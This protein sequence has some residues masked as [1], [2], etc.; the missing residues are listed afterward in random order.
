MG[1]LLGLGQASFAVPG[2]QM[3]EHALCIN[4][5]PLNKYPLHLCQ[6]IFFILHYCCC[7]VTKSCSTLC[8]PMVTRQALLSFTNSQSL[9]RLMC[10]E[11]VIPS[12]YLILCHPIFL[13]SI[14][15][16]IR[17]FSN[18]SALHTRWP[19]YWSFSISSSSEYSRFISFR[20][21]C[22]GPVN[23]EHDAKITGSI[24]CTGH[25]LWSPQQ[26]GCQLFGEENGKPLQY[27]CLENL[28]NNIHI[29]FHN[30]MLKM[31]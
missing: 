30:K 26:G 5:Y 24:S 6:C 28:M 22:Q 17:V 11:S 4:N 9:L 13:P 8:N 23:S 31:L 1:S 2:L 7:S 19:K 15:P 20:I 25:T 21:D 10:T 27:S 29:I 14:F 12:N 18:E 16:S 3:Y